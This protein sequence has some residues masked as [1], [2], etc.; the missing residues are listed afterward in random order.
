MNGFSKINDK[1]RKVLEFLVN[2]SDPCEGVEE[3]MCF[4]FKGIS[5]HTKLHIP[6]VR[7]ACRSLLRKGLTEFHRGLMDDE[8]KEAGSGYCAT[9]MGQALISHCDLCTNRNTYEYHVDA[10][11]KTVFSVD[12]KARLVKECEDHYKKSAERVEQPPLL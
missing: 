7:R 4:F 3:G 8:G 9:Y 1:E 11:G 5:K 12:G 2:G 6:A 10:D